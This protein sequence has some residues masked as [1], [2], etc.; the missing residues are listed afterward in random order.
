[1]HNRKL[2]PL[3][4]LHFAKNIANVTTLMAMQ[5]GKQRKGAAGEDTPL[6]AGA[7]L[8]S[9]AHTS[10]QVCSK[11]DLLQNFNRMQGHLPL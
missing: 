2:N 4:V 8:H 10:L 9:T 5:L 3:R 1:M 7:H 6:T 11:L